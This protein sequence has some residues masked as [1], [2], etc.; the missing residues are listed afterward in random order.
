[1]LDRGEDP[2]AKA[3]AAVVAEKEREWERYTLQEAIDEHVRNMEAKHCTPKTIAQLKDEL[4]RHTADWLTWPLAR[5]TRKDCIE[6]HRKITKDSGPYAANR[7]VRELRA[8][9]NSARRLFEKLPPH[10]L[11]GVTLNKEHRRREPIPFTDLPTWGEKVDAMQ[12]HVRRDYQWFVLLTGSRQTAART[13]RWENVD[14]D[15]GTVHFSKPK[16]GV[17]R[18]FTIPLCAHLLAVLAKRKLA[19]RI[20][21]PGGDKGWVFPTFDRDGNVMAMVDPKVTKYADQPDGTVKKVGSLPSPHRLRD[22]WATAA[23]E[24]G[25]DFLTIQVLMNHSLPNGSVT[26]GYMRPSVEHL[27]LGVERVAKFLLVKAG[28]VVEEKPLARVGA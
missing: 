15:K 28:V 7:M 3:R 14:F 1:M 19:N 24:S 18:A 21:C 26:A 17:D 11:V 13:L 16:G 12:N 22:T 8:V 5:I 27:R 10:P 20:L 4:G 6:K 23:N 9:W 2:L 25:V